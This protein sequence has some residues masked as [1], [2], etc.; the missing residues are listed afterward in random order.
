MKRG[1]PLVT[2]EAHLLDL[3]IRE[4]EGRVGEARAHLTLVKKGPRSEDLERACVDFMNAESDRQRFEALRAKE[5]VS[6][7]QQ[8]DTARAVAE[9]KRQLLA[10]LTKQ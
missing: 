9:T 3:T 10:E 1:Q 2:L 8:A 4:Q 6:A 5:I 7:A